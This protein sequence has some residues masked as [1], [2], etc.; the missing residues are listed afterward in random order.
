M[1]NNYWA[2]FTSK[3]VESDE[4]SI[5]EAMTELHNAKDYDAVAVEFKD[6][7]GEDLSIKMRA[8]LDDDLY[9]SIFVGHL[10]QQYGYS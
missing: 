6:L 1:E 9:K 3:R 4:M 7:T 8:E 5:E 10:L 2:I